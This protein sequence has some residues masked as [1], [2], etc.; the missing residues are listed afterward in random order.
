MAV[1]GEDKRATRVMCLTATEEGYQVDDDRA[2]DLE[3]EW[4]KG[5][6]LDVR[7]LMSIPGDLEH[8]TN[9]GSSI[10]DRSI[11]CLHQAMMGSE[12][13]SVWA[14]LTRVDGTA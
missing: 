3:S 5:T 12:R 10:G 13:A 6:L 11:H 14:M 1:C 8:H 2:F 4:Q 9:Q 7:M